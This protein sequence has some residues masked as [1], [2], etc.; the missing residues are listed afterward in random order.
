MTKPLP[1]SQLTIQDAIKHVIAAEFSER[2][3]FIKSR[4]ELEVGVGSTQ[5][6]T[7]ELSGELAILISEIYNDARILL[8]QWLRDG[9]IRS[10]YSDP[11]LGD[12]ELLPS[13]W[14]LA[15]TDDAILGGDYI[16]HGDPRFAGPVGLHYAD[17]L[18][19]VIG[20]E[21][22]YPAGK[23]KIKTCCNNDDEINP[24]RIAP[25]AGRDSNST[26]IATPLLD[27]QPSK[28]PTGKPRKIAGATLAFRAIYGPSM[29]R[30]LAYKVQLKAVQQWYKDQGWE[31]PTFSARTF[32]RI[33]N[34]GKNK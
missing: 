30:G 6:K 32:N 33:L 10:F 11:W 1:Q 28:E 27:D 5:K 12:V 20:G 9:R 4:I 23:R 8:R 34:P 3:Q 31:V 24:D 18:R 15:I 22:L 25:D 16:A 2:D 14:G 13:A 29:G 26:N 19:I 7:T 21:L 17:L